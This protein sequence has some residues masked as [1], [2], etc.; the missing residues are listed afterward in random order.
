MRRKNR[1]KIV[2]KLLLTVVFT[3]VFAAGAIA[4]TGVPQRDP[5]SGRG[6]VNYTYGSGAYA[7]RSDP[8]ILPR[9]PAFGKG[10]A[11]NDTFNLPNETDLARGGY[12][13]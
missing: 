7:S 3:S 13:R 1:E 5:Y 11:D 9:D 12:Y 8:S 10:N 4:R 2:K 6:Y